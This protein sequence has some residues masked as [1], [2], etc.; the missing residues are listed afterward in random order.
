MK[1]FI[2]KLID[3]LWYV[4]D[5]NTKNVLFKHKD[6]EVVEAWLDHAAE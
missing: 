3:K 4:V 5:A 6:K 2:I 1:T